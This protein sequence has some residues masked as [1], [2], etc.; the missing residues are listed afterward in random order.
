MHFVKYHLY[1]T[2]RHIQLKD[3]FFHYCIIIV[4]D[5]ISFIQ[6][7]KKTFFALII[8]INILASAVSFAIDTILII[9]NI[10]H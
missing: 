2:D 6:K 5:Y 1:R 4:I 10:L 7:E 8:A 9:R 3:N